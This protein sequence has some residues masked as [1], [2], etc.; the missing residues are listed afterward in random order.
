[1]V[2]LALTADGGRVLV[3]HFRERRANSLPS[4]QAVR[5]GAAT[6]AG[7]VHREHQ[8]PGG[9]HRRYRQ[10]PGGAHRRRRRRRL[11]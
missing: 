11:G 10:Q 1:M 3:L 4:A 9:G 6:A 7:T 5:Q 8:R 2:P